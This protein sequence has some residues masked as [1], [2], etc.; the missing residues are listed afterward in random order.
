VLSLVGC[1]AE[2]AQAMEEE[3]ALLLGEHGRDG[4]LGYWITSMKIV[5]RKGDWTAL[6]ESVIDKSLLSMP[7]YQQR[8]KCLTLGCE[9]ADMILG[10][11]LDR[12]EMLKEFCR[13]HEETAE[14]VGN[15]CTSANDANNSHCFVCFDEIE[16]ECRLLPCGHATCLSCCKAYLKSAAASG[17]GS[18]QC[19]AH[20]CNVSMNIFDA[21]HILT[22]DHE[23]FSRMVRFAVERNITK[24]GTRFCPSTNCGRLLRPQV[25][26]VE[27]TQPGFNIRICDCGTVACGECEHEGHPGVPCGDF[28]KLHS[29]IDSGGLD[30]EIAK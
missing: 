17:Q 28:R 4:W 12:Y 10:T 14:L 6:L 22:D 11:C 9:N 24:Q 15:A 1:S 29:A 2:I 25:G 27:S 16:T 3:I 18:I 20:K 26:A 8:W 21:A 13:T 19:S 30:A 23:T 5:E 7:P